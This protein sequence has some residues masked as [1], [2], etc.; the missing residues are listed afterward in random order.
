MQPSRNFPGPGP[1]LS[2]GETHIE[3]ARQIDMKKYLVILKITLSHT[4]EA[5]SKTE[6]E[7]LA[8]DLGE[9]HA[10]IER[11]REWKAQVVK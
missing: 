5:N 1:G 4:V 8:R 9:H 2:V 6:A 10:D 11:V 3:K 7:S